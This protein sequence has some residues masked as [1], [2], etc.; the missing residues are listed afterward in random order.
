MSRAGGDAAP[1]VSLEN[2]A[3]GYDGR[4][5]V[6]GVSLRLPRGESAVLLG[7]NGGGKSTLCRVLVGLAEPLAGRAAVLGRAPAKARND[8][9]FVSQHANLTGQTPVTVFDVAAAGRLAASARPQRLTREDRASVTEAIERVDLAGLS[10][11]RVDELSG[12]QLR[13]TLLARAL[14][15][16]ARV[17]V[18]DE[19]LAGLDHAASQAFIELLGKLLGD[20]SVVAASHHHEQFAP[21][22]P[23]VITVDGL[24]PPPAGHHTGDRTASTDDKPGAAPAAEPS[25]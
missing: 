1:A 21:L 10:R 4:P 22:H 16:N 13:R 24:R 17:L 6:S 5:V 9:A 8:V 18:L 25:K 23:T 11:R 20:V 7:P 15:A 14:A 2:V 12:G 3:A 19:P